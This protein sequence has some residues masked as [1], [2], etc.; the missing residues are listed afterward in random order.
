MG[1]TYL[2]QKPLFCRAELLVR[3]FC[4][5]PPCE[6]E[7]FIANFQSLYFWSHFDNSTSCAIAKHLWMLDKQ[8]TVILVH[9]Q[10]C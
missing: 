7:D 5:T 1:V 2:R 3:L 9:I 8:G 6:A 10:W 4:L